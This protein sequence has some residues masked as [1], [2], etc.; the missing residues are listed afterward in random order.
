MKKNFLGSLFFLVCF[1]IPVYAQ[2]NDD[3]NAPQ[4]SMTPPEPLE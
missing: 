3:K 1:V 4:Q 2:Q